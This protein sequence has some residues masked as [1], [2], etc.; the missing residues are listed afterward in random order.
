MPTRALARAV[1]RAAA[2]V[3]AR[4][5]PAGVPDHTDPRPAEV[6]RR[7]ARGRSPRASLVPLLLTAAY[8]GRVD[9]PAAVAAAA[10][11]GRPAGGPVADVLG[12]PGEAPGSRAAG[13]AAPAAG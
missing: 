13:R 1:R 9:M 10:R 12:R 8:H 11:P 6:L 4:S 7:L 2:A 5:G 3:H